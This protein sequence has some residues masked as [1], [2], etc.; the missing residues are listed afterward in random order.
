M[1]HNLGQVTM[2]HVR[3]DTPL[4]VV[5]LVS[6]Y[7][8]AMPW[9]QEVSREVYMAHVIQSLLTSPTTRREAGFYSMMLPYPIWVLHEGTHSNVPH[10]TVMAN[11]E[12]YPE[13]R[14]HGVLY[15]QLSNAKTRMDYGGKIITPI[16]PED[17][18]EI[19]LQNMT[20][21]TPYKAPPRRTRLLRRLIDAVEEQMRI[22]NEL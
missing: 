11:P 22:F 13:G 8:E 9:P 7:A 19:G 3:V 15:V 6:S 4:H 10:L 16:G 5:S 18:V 1:Y 17:M 12:R 14:Y 21:V 2:Q 20:M